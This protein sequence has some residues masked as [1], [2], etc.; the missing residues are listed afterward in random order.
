MKLVILLNGYFSRHNLCYWKNQE[1][2]GF[3]LGAGFYV[4]NRRGSNTR[5]IDKYLRGEYLYQEFFLT[6]EER[7]EYEIMLSFRL[8]KGIDLDVFYQKYHIYLRDLYD[9]DDLILSHFLVESCH[10]LSI[11]EEKIYVSNEI[12]VKFL[13]KRTKFVI[14]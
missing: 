6:L 4:Q 2:Y 3:G 10:H 13:G 7:I 1:Y 5:S 9:Y 8:L 14:K 11:P 12:I